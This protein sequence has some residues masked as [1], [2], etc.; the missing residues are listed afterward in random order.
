MEMRAGR[1]AG[2]ADKADQLAAGDR[3]SDFH[4]KLGKMAVAGDQA[5]AMVDLDHLAVAA[6]PAGSGDRAV[7]R[8]NDKIATLAVDVHTGMKFVYP[9]AEGISPE[10]EFIIDLAGVRPHVRN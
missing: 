7:S 3:I 6:L 5:V 2:R 1:A 8:S 4:V 10:A 9:T